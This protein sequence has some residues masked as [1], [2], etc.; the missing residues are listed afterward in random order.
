VRH[1]PVDDV[2]GLV[3]DRHH[4]LGVQLAQGDL[5]PG[6]RA[7]NL[8]HAVQFEVE[9]LTDAHPGG[10]QQ[11]QRV[12]AQPIRCGVQRRG[13]PPVG[14]RGQVARQGAGQSGDISREDELAAGCLSPAPLVDVVD[15]PA[16]GADPGA[17]FG[18]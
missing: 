16:D 11:Q 18:W 1:D 15:Q 8:V 10:A 5:Q 17:P 3:V 6:S 9:E 13:E 2:E 7:G 14:V 12:G 4:P